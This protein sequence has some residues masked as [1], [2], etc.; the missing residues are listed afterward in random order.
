LTGAELE[1]AWNELINDWA[2]VSYEESVAARRFIETVRDRVIE[3][4]GDT[5]DAVEFQTAA[6]LG[7]TRLKAFWF[8]LN[9]R[10]G[11]QFA[12]DKP[13]NRAPAPGRSRFGAIRGHRTASSRERGQEVD[14][15]CLP[16]SPTM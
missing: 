13:R 5:D 11:F 1:S 14:A 15:F 3:G 6:L 8:E 9:S 10:I 2:S 7:F 4:L 16:W 12:N